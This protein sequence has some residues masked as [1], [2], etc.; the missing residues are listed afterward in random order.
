MPEDR[1]I[2]T[3]AAGPADHQLSYGL[4]PQQIVEFRFAA[5]PDAGAG[6]PVGPLILLVHGGFWRPEYDRVH[7]RPAAEALAAAGWTTALIEYVRVPGKP[8]ETVRDVGL[9]LCEVPALTDRYDGRVIVLGHS[10]GA[11]LALLAASGP[12]QPPARPVQAAVSEPA[13]AHPAA[14]LS[15]VV[16]LGAVADLR[17]ADEL[18]LDEGAVRAFI[19]ADPVTRPDLDPRR[20][21]P[22]V[23]VTL[24]HGTDDAIV[25]PA[26]A[27]SYA[28]VHPGVRLVSVEGAGHY[29]LIDPASAAWDTVL[30]E[31]ERLSGSAAA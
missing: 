17:L 19:G 16:A 31:L 11:Y 14:K 13:T 25:P 3:R 29:A 5:G 12:G 18:N 7:L 4:A 24:V 21:L 2:L 23:P 27:Q 10:A 9:A 8:D 30:A 28:R 6:A 1:S 26:L 22:R 20:L 15:A